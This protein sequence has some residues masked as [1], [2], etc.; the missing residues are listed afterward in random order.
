MNRKRITLPSGGSVVVRKLSRMDF[1]SSDRI[2]LAFAAESAS[3]KSGDDV[4]LAKFAAEIGRIALL[5]ACGTITLPNGKPLR[6]VEKPFDECSESET[7]IE[8]LDDSDAEAIIAA[9]SELTNL[10]RE[11]GRAVAPFPS[12]QAP[13]DPARSD[14]AALR[15]APDHAPAAAVG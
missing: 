13:A 15:A 6:I 11:A 12:G 10:N 14:G 7:T 8:M 3:G 9:V 2:P 5:R 1:L 4:Q